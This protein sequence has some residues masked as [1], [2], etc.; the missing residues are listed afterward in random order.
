MGLGQGCT[1]PG[2]RYRQQIS[3]P[4]SAGSAPGTAVAAGRWAAPAARLQAKPEIGLALA[5]RMYQYEEAQRQA[6]PRR[7]TFV[8]FAGDIDRTPPPQ[9]IQLEPPSEYP[10]TGDLVIAAHLR[11]RASLFAG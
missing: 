3:P 1:P 5:V 7:G 4:Q 11:L 6:F 9:A 2:C 8:A 10:A